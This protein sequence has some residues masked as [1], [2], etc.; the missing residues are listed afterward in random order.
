MPDVV[1][2][3][4]PALT[5][6]RAA[7]EELAERS[8]R[9]G[10]EVSVDVDELLFGRAALLGFE[11]RGRIS[12]NG[13]CR[14]LA[15]VDGWAAVNLARSDDVASVPAILGRWVEG[16]PWVALEAAATGMPS[17]DLVDQAQLLGVPAAAL[18][19]RTATIRP[20]LPV[21]ATAGRVR[22]RRAVT[23]TDLGARSVAGAAGRRPLV[24]V[25]GSAV[26][27]A[28]RGGRGRGRQGR[29]HG[30]PRRRP[31]HARVLLPAQRGQGRSGRS[32]SAARTGAP[33]SIGS[34]RLRTWSSSRRDRGALR[35]LGIVAEEVVGRTGATW[36]SITGYGREGP[37]GDRVAFGDDAAVAGG[38]VG[39]DASGDPVFFGDAVADPI[40][41]LFAAL[42]V[43]ASLET[44]GGRLLDCAARRRRRLRRRSFRSPVARAELLR[45]PRGSSPF[46]AL[47][48]RMTA[49]TIVGG[50]V[51]GVAGLGVRVVDGRIVAV[52]PDV[53]PASGDEARRC[54]RW[55][56]DPRLARP[57]PPSPRPR[58]G[59]GLG[60]SRAARGHE[61]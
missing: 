31:R 1:A 53:E 41:G 24:V 35:Q 54:A 49:L 44:G 5:K 7:A 11:P 30:S 26:R 38:L 52:G 8:R 36:V 27:P 34:C 3:A 59:G 48:R 14:L 6:V 25:G 46:G 45:A 57:P 20:P 47:Q 10:R 32:T 61:P 51:D 18:G 56:G 9:L 15:T 4:A 19:E 17:R 33:S 42:G 50:E 55:R 29:E 60:A 28:A 21:L 58:R 12:A 2:P 13:T 40:T 37:D 16:D 22:A 43:M 23:R 39:T